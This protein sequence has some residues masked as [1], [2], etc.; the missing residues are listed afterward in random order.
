M[1]SFLKQWIISIAAIVVFMA[2]VELILPSNNF[3]KYAK[4]V[5]GLIVIVMI[6]SPIFKLFSRNTDASAVI[7]SYSEVLNE[8]SSKPDADSINNS[9]NQKTIDTF[10]QNLK[11]SIQKQLLDDSGKTYT[12]A[13]IDLNEDPKSSKY[14]SIKSISIK[15][16][17]ENTSIKP[18]EKVVIGSNSSTDIPAEKDKKVI[19]ILKTKYDIDPSSVKF[20]K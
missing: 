7:A 18:V 10:K 17:P 12:V 2:L 4:F 14:L 13:G 5:M 11:E 15:L 3:K 1:L 8:N 9:I 20:I 19:E 6:M 16:M